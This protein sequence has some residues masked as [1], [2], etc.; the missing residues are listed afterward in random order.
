MTIYVGG[1][2]KRNNKAEE[3]DEGTEK[4][5]KIIIEWEV[6]IS[7]CCKSKQRRSYNRG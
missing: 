5:N 4:K 7:I 3:S 6:K 1:E 2:S